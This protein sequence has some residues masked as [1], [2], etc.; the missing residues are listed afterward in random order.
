VVEA[1]LVDSAAVINILK[2][3]GRVRHLLTMP[4]KSTCTHVVVLAIAFFSILDLEELWIAFGAGK[5]F[6]YITIHEIAASLGQEK[7]KSLS[8]FHAFTGCDQTS[9][10][11]GR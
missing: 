4:V 8:L 9:A 7:C 2:P 5:A 3:K 6:R 10:F 11:A 1:L